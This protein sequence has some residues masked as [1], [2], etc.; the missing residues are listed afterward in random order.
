MRSQ[1]LCHILAYAEMLVAWQLP[2]KRAEL[3]KLVE[4]EVQGLVPEDIVADETLYSAP[5]GERLP[6]VSS[7]RRYA[8]PVPRLSSTLWTLRTPSKFVYDSVPR[9]WQSSIHLLF[10]LPPHDQR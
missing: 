8:E 2:E 5:I 1:L 7:D 10:C 6:H 4:D 9:M 3:L